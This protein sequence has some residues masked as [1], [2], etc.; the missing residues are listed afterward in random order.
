MLG[1]RETCW[2]SERERHAEREIKQLEHV[3]SKGY[4]GMQVS[5]GGTGRWQAD[6][7]LAHICSHCT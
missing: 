5:A 3:T 7:Y 1:E 4:L 6:L 2:K